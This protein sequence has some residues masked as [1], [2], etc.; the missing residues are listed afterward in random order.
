MCLA[1][2]LGERMLSD[3]IDQRSATCTIALSLSTA[4]VSTRQISPHVQARDLRSDTTDKT[5]DTSLEVSL[6]LLAFLPTSSLVRVNHTKCKR[7]S[8]VR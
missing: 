2:V 5:D 4:L 7:E 1:L 3:E 6:G 8:H